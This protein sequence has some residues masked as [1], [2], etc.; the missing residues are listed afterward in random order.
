MNNYVYNMSIENL[1]ESVVAACISVATV[2][3][4][5]IVKRTYIT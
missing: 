3:T 4:L 2:Q 5:K 1:Q